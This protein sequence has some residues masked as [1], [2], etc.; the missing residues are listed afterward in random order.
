MAGAGP[1]GRPLAVSGSPGAAAPAPGGEAVL[2][3]ATVAALAGFASD[4]SRLTGLS[5]AMWMDADFT[6]ALVGGPGPMRPAVD[7]I[8]LEVTGGTGGGGATLAGWVLHGVPAVGGGVGRGGTSVRPRRIPLA[9]LQ[10]SGEGVGDVVRG[11]DLMSLDFRGVR[12]V[13]PV[14]RPVPYAVEINL[15]SAWHITRYGVGVEFDPGFIPSSWRLKGRLAGK[16]TWV[17]LHDVGADGDSGD[18]SDA[19]ADEDEGT[20]DREDA[21]SDEDADGDGNDDSEE[22]TDDDESDNEGEDGEE[23]GD[24]DGDESED[25]DGDAGESEDVSTKEDDEGG[26]LI[27]RI[28]VESWRLWWFDV[29]APFRGVLRRR[30][31]LVFAA[32]RGL[33]SRVA[34]LIGAGADVNASDVDGTTQSNHRGRRVIHQRRRRNAAV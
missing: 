1:G 25:E 27:M 19:A 3:V 11:A 33:V 7:A 32:R 10:L 23:G 24:G 2:A 17:T 21:G 15:M 16:G 34:Q 13:L 5:R 31:R 12:P 6:A 8:R 30:P 20:N 18:D 29:P 14:T 28:E 4:V 9:V 26:R 22:G